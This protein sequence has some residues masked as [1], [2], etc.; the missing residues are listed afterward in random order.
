MG[1]LFAQVLEE[2]QRLR[3]DAREWDWQLVLVAKDVMPPFALPEGRIFVSPKWVADRRLSDAEIALLLAHEIAHVL[4]EHMLER[5][6]ALA[7]ARPARITRVADVLRMIE[8]E[9]YVAREL[10]PLMQAQELEADRIGLRLVCAAGI[11]PHTALTLF[12][13]MARAG[14]GIT[15]VKSHDGPLERKAAL[16]SW[17]RLVCLD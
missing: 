13:K 1:R 17:A 7:T 15:Y 3:P 2:A 14:H 9:W 10:E 6:S 5:V 16:T 8:Q 4:S 11:A 12:D